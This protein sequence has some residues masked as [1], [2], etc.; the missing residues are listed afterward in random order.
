MA[1]QLPLYRHPT[2]T[3]L[4]DDDRSSLVCLQFQIEHSLAKKTFNKARA[5]LEWIAASFKR[6]ARIGGPVDV[7]EYSEDGGQRHSSVDREL[8]QIYRYVGDPQRFAMPAVVVIDYS[9]P[10][11]NG[12]EFCEAVAHY[13]CKKILFTSLAD[14]KTGIDAFNRGLIQRFQKKQEPDSLDR[15]EIAIDEMQV[16]YF[17]ELS[18]AQADRLKPEAFAFLSDASVALLVR[19]LCDRYG[20]VEYYLFS[21]PAGFLFFDADGHPTLMVVQTAA[22]LAAQHQAARAGGGMDSALLDDLRECR[23]VPFFPTVDGMWRHTLDGAPAAY[24]KLAQV[25]RGDEDFYWA[26]FE[27]PAH[28][29]KQAPYSHARFLRE[30]VALGA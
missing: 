14:D 17:I 27:L 24:C 22:A 20:F 5:A 16:Q 30:H 18:R 7:R 15:L 25:C 4:I 23:V 13:P 8:E 10:D 3:V 19:D 6:A 2:L 9:M 28:Y 29:K 12:V 11:M 26:L 1:A 21:N